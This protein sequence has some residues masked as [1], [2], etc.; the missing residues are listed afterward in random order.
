MLVTVE[1]PVEPPDE[2]PAGLPVG[3][4]AGLPAGL[5]VRVLGPLEAWRDGA[6]IAIG[7]PKA[8]TVLAVLVANRSSVVSVDRLA[9]ALWGDDPPPSA[10][11]TMQSN[12][13][14]LRKAL[15]PALD[16]T[17]RAPG[18]VL[19]G[20]TDGVDAAQFEQLVA[21][22]A[23][24]GSPEAVVALVERALALWRGPAFDEFAD[25]DWARGEAV[26]LEELR[27]IAVERLVDA[28]LAL[29]RSGAVVSE[30]DRLVI[31]HPLRERF[32]R[33][34]MVALYR[35]GRQAEALRRANE[36]RTHLN[37]LGLDL[38]PAARELES[39]I[40]ADDPTL[41]VQGQGADARA[42]ASDGSARDRNPLSALDATRFVGRDDDIVAIGRLLEG[43]RLV[44]LV[45][46]GG[47]GKTRLAL[48][49]AA[50]AS[51]VGTRPTCVV[52]L[53]ATR[54]ERA[55]IQAVAAALE[56]EQRQHLSLESTL[57]EFLR[58]REMLIVLDNCE[59][60]VDTLAP[61]VDSVR[62]SCP[63]I[64]VLATSREPLGLSGERT[65]PVRPLTLPDGDARSV[66]NI[67]TS[68]AVQLLVD[69]AS[70]AN[71][72]FVLTEENAA[73]VAEICRRLDGLP[74]ALELAAARLRT[75]GP[76]ALAEG[77]R[78]R[79]HVLGA[80]QR[81]ADHRHRTLRDTLEWSYDL[82]TPAEQ[83]LFGWL[84]TFV[85]GFNLRAA[86]H[87]CAIDDEETD[88]ADVLANLV[89]KSM[90][91][92]VDLD[93]PR[94]RLLETLREFGLDRLA[95]RG[96]RNEPRSRHLAWYAQVARENAAG[97]SG[98]DEAE[99]VARFDRDLD[100][101]REAHT[102][103][104]ALGDVDGAVSL[105]ASLREYAFR[106]MRYEV[107]AW[108]ESTLTMPA[109]EDHPRAPIVVAVAAYGAFVRGDL[110]SA[111]RH[112]DHAVALG[113]A[114]GT[115]SSG[116]AER[117]LGNAVFYQGDVE[118]GLEW[119]DRMVESARASG[120]RARLAHAL[121]MRSVAASSV[122]D[123]DLGSALAE[124]STVIAEQCASPTSRAQAAYAVGVAREGVAPDDAD[125][126]LRR[127][128]DAARVA[129]NRW[130]EAFALTEVMWLDARKG[131]PARALAGFATVID[132]WYR[133]GDWTNQWLS[134]RHVCGILA[135]LGADRSAAVLFGSIAAAGAAA[136]L[137]FEPA[138]A[139]RLGKLVDELRRVLGPAAFADAVR[140]GAATRDATLV[141]FV[142]DEIIR[143]TGHERTAPA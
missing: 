42:E 102:N 130:V 47:V 87:V 15:A 84:G 108:A 128:V 134:L 25:L 3:L 12:V 133:G 113:D 109:F 60:L 51:A 11:A 52:E 94:Y 101:F 67:A 143:L 5:M 83:R 55:A 2:L 53:S 139:E 43:E 74:L 136:A 82:L 129:G 16:I 111:I 46:A 78:R 89:D 58:D 40:I 21:D 29:G 132:T 81:G 18:Y 28:Q 17:A 4:P 114:L 77:L 9:D 33:Q 71:P 36:L 19:D 79:M 91:Q 32:W 116:L 126:S 34:L 69:R 135:Q 59:H 75:L 35:T 122:G 49:L 13:S 63:D 37:E 50:T 100:N 68:E 115:D 99:S 41:A 127:S 14:R 73:A 1:S 140:E 120:S 57:V 106:R 95:E 112:A 93:E 97:L 80:A 10:T 137:P 119:M 121:Y 48:R 6:A 65:W 105:V 26:R 104:V 39:R 107:S 103:A 38:S 117:V 56:V 76:T 131:N 118:S 66:D 85:G 72:G 125:A 20:P 124:E 123:V 22:A 54:D 23:V 138:D 45:G 27:L 7:G 44:T 86:E 141:R 98:P 70:A 64:T 90:V 61:F 24:A 88:V 92:V 110:E 31:E 96:E 30:L 8:R 142:Q 62:T